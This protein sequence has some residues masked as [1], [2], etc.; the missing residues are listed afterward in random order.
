MKYLSP[1]ILLFAFLLTSF[2]VPRVSAYGTGSA[3]DARQEAQPP[4]GREVVGAISEAFHTTSRAVIPSVV[5]IVLRRGAANK[6]P[7]KK[8]DLYGDFS[9]GRNEEEGSL[10]SVGSGVLVD[11]SGIVL[12][13]NHVI[14]EGGNIVVVLYDGR[15]FNVTSVKGDPLSD[16][17]VLTLDTQEKLPHLEFADSDK[18]EIGDWVLAIGTPFMLESSVSAGIISAKKRSLRSQERGSYIQTDAAINPG[19]SGGPLVDLNGRIVGINTA[20]ASLSGGNQGIGFAIPANT[21]CWVMKEL[22]E[23]GKV[24]RA[25]LGAPGSPLSYEESKRLGLSPRE[26]VKI[27]TPFR[28]SPAAKAGIRKNDIILAFDDKRL[29]S[30]E[31]FQSMIE[32]AD[33]T[34]THTLTV[35]R[36]GEPER[37]RLLVKLEIE[38]EGYV[39][40]P[41]VENLVEAGKHYADTATGLM[42]IPMT[43]SAAERFGALP[44]SGIVI[45]SVM[46]GSRAY[47]AGLRDGMVVLK[48]NG[49]PTPSLDEYKR[50]SGEIPAENNRVF[51]VIAKKELIEITVP[52]KP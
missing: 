52:A 24:E 50:V 13:N 15:R 43:E 48:L 2:V 5:K 11:P 40:V 9:T 25:F 10:V 36:K 29:D 14:M 22:V 28:D 19:N 33:V 8:L 47:R 38:P 45:L 35:L 18:I 17:A 49:I 31:A 1:A 44:D 37:L 23:K 20:I 26:G 27:D 3:R 39:G 4:S 42:L 46:P 34:R 32:S 41:Q 6:S 30:V 51:E 16:L 7:K 21:A 12:T